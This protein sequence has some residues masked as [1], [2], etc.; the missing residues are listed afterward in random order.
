MSE[1]RFQPVQANPEEIDE[2]VGLEEPAPGDLRRLTA[3][4]TIINSA[5]RVGLAALSLL[6]RLIVAAFLTAEEFGLWGIVIAAV[7]TL[8]WLK[9]IGI[10]DKYVQQSEPDQERAF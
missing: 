10:A 2:A 7:I 4:G 8:A 3:R 5:F 6:Q 1:A 9:E